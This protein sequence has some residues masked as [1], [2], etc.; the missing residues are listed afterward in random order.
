LP[1]KESK[2]QSSNVRAVNVRVG[3]QTN[4][5]ITQFRYIKIIFADARAERRNQS[6]DFAVSEHFIKTRFL[7]VQNFTF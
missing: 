3:H 6:L 7:D 2:E 4:F 1:V 5:V